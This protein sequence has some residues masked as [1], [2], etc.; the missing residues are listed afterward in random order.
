[1]AMFGIQFDPTEGEASTPR[2]GFPVIPPGKYPA[3][4]VESSRRE[5][6]PDDPNH[7]FNLKFEIVDG[8]YVGRNIW[9]DIRFLNT[10]SE[11]Q[12]YG[13]RDMKAIC[14]ATNTLKA[15]STED[16]HFKTFMLHLRVKLKGFQEK[17]RKDGTPGYI[18]Q[19][20]KNEVSGYSA[21]P[22]GVGLNYQPRPPREASA[23][24]GGGYQQPRPAQQPAMAGAGAGGGG[25]PR[26]GSSG[27]R[28]WEDAAKRQG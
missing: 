1:M 27:Y 8:E 25:A 12:E 22:A 18:H 2:D 21:A 26:P 13:Q 5:E 23:P 11:A 19:K 4:I 6:D 3:Q 24:A 17:Q 14:R 9:T 16:L 20:D 7:T 28:P 10:N 15:A